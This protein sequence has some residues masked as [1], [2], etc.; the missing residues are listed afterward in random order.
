MR[1][2]T[3]R[4]QR[5]N[6]ALDVLQIE[7]ENLHEE[8]ETKTGEARQKLLIYQ[9]SKQ[10]TE[11]AL[12]NASEKY[13]EALSFFRQGDVLFEMLG[14]LKAEH[15]TL[16]KTVM[17]ETKTDAAGPVTEQILKLKQARE[18]LKKLYAEIQ[19]LRA[20]ALPTEPVDTPSAVGHRSAL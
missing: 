2:L 4:I 7:L 3:L 5:H 14:K 16:S 17:A 6:K 19:K 8:V 1:N 15:I 10:Q 11:N 18:H 13:E 9:T 12:E 20:E